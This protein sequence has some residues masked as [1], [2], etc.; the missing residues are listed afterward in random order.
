[1]K[2]EVSVVKREETWSKK[3]RERKRREREKANT[4]QLR[5][6]ERKMVKE[7]VKVKRKNG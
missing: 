7:A 2:K 1:M 5:E 3:E 6:K 4:N